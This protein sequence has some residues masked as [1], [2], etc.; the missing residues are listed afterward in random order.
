M[1]TPKQ[2]NEREIVLNAAHHDHERSMN[3]FALFKTHNHATGQDLVQDTFIK[4]W[5]YLVKGGED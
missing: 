3:S 2:K 4:T 1:M 5:G